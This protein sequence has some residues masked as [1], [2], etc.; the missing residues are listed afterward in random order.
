MVSPEIYSRVPPGVYSNCFLAVWEHS[1][2]KSYC[3]LIISLLRNMLS[4]KQR[5]K[6]FYLEVLSRSYA[7]KVRVARAFQ[8]GERAVNANYCKSYSYTVV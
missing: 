1:L 2:G 4:K 3:Y 8:S 5:M 6:D 7:N